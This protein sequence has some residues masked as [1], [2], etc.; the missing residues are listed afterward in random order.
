MQIFLTRA[1]IAE[2]LETT[3]GVAAALLAEKGVRP[4]DWGRGRGR[5]LRWYAPAVEQAAREMHE[6]AQEKN[7]KIPKRTTLPKTGL[8]V[9]RSVNDL[10]AELTSDNKM[11]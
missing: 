5:G 7:I 8:V 9:G 11:Q 10:Y 4:V 1:Q 2:R 3:A 6:E